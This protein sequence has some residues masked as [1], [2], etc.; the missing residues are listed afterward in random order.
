MWK[1]SKGEG[2]ARKIRCWFLMGCVGKFQGGS[3]ENWAFCLA[4]VDFCGDSEGS[5]PLIYILPYSWLLQQENNLMVGS[6]IFGAGRDFRDLY[7][8]CLRFR[9]QSG[10]YP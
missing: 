5:V 2:V 8:E 10:K 9:G 1:A 6:W 4:G 3:Y 7:F